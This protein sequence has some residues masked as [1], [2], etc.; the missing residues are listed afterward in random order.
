MKVEIRDVI[1]KDWD[2]ILKI[3]NQHSNRIAFHDTTITS[4]DTHRKYMTKL[5]DDPN[6]FHWIIMY[7]EKAVGHIKIVN[8]ELG[9]FLLDGYKGKGIGTNAHELV[10]DKAKQ[11]GLKKL[12]ATIKV[13]RP[14]PL[15][16]EEKLG[17]VKKKIVY[18]NNKAYSYY[19]EKI[20]D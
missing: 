20:L 3:R 9:Y 18:K 14:T 15:S 1:E 5:R 2:F 12:A 7:G 8:S 10:Y 6:S 16:F 19:I 17:W 13:E 11:L 4:I